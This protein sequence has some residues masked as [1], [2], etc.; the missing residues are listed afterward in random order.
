MET[1]R[2]VLVGEIA[3]CSFM[4]MVSAMLT[5]KGISPLQSLTLYTCSS[6]FCASY[7][8]ESGYA[9]LSHDSD[10]RKYLPLC[11]IYPPL[12]PSP[13]TLYTSLDRVSLS[14]QL[15]VLHTFYSHLISM[16]CICMCVYIRVP[17]VWVWCVVRPRSFSL[18]SSLW[19]QVLFSLYCLLCEV[20]LS[21]C[22]S[23]GY[24]ISWPVATWFPDLC[25]L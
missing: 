20:S 4:L 17:H 24:L 3:L 14:S 5:H 9:R 23:N 6:D 16:C 22:L 15:F 2:A 12:V 1:G 21:A 8:S 11:Q 18:T 19:A 25:W 7:L 10:S 13:L